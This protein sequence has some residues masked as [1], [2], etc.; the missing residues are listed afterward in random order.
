MTSRK[1]K[2]R[3]SGTVTSQATGEF[4][5]NIVIKAV[6]INN[7]GPIL[8]KA[9]TNKKGYYK[10][11]LDFN[12]LENTEIKEIKVDILL[13]LE[14]SKGRLIRALKK[15]IHILSTKDD[16]LDISLQ[17]IE[18]GLDWQDMSYI[19]GQ[20]VNLKAVAQLSNEELVQT[21]RYLRKRTKKLKRKA[22]VRK[23][24][25]GLFHKFTNPN[26]DCGEGR[27]E[28]IHV[29]MEDRGS[30][31]Q[32][33][34]A[35]DLPAGATVHWFFTN[36]IQVKY[37]TDAA[38]PNDRVNPALPASDQQVTLSDGTPIGWIR[39]NLSD[40]HP[41]NTEVS[42]AYV[43]RVGLIAEFALSRF[44]SLAFAMRDPRN[45]AS[46][47]EYRIRD[48]AG[49]AGQ[50]SGS[51]SHVEVA[52]SNSDLQNLHTVP[53]EMFHQVQYRYNNTTTRS[54]IYGSLREGGSRF[55]EDNIND[56]PNRYVAQSKEIFDDPS[57]S[58][59]DSVSVGTS[60]GSST[61]IR[62]AAALFWK[63]IAEHHSTNV[64]PA[65]EPVIGI[66]SYRKVLE[67][68][69]TVQMSDP[70][71]GYD[72][73]VLRTARSGMPYYGRLDQFRYYDMA[74]TELDH[75]ET[76]WANYL[77]ANYV[78]STGNPVAD[79]RF[80]Y[81]EDQ[82]PVTWPSTVANLA[83][84]QAFI[85]PGDNLT[86]AQ[87]ASIS[88]SVVGHKQ[89]SSRY[90]RV[91][92][93]GSPGPRL[94]RI[95]LI[96][97]A[98]MTDPLIQILRLGASSN[99]IDINRSDKM[100][101][102]KT[103]N[104][105]GLSQVIVI[106]A[107]RINP[108]D[109]T[110]QFDEVATGAD[111][112]ITRWNSAVGTEYEIDPTGWSWT[113]ISP[114]VMV[115]NN[116]DGFADT[117]VFFGQNNKLK[118]RLRNRGNANAS[119]IQIDFWYQKATPFLNSGGWIPVQDVNG[120]TQQITGGTLSSGSYNWFMVNWAPVDDGT[121]HPHWCVKVKVT[122]PGE[123]NIDNKM[124]FSN[125]GNVTTP[126]E[127]DEVRILVRMLES[128]GNSELMVIPHGPLY[129]FEAPK[130]PNGSGIYKCKC[131][132][133]DQQLML[134]TRA[135]RT[136]MKVLERKLKPWDR[137]TRSLKPLQEYY[138]HVKTNTLP[139]GVDPKSLVT[140][141]ELTDGEVMGGITY[142]VLTKTSRKTTKK[143]NR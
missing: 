82:D 40:L 19:A 3:I 11:V 44:I 20:P 61:S 126:G 51:W 62:Y 4:I 31:N 55:I 15:P 124:C 111:T 122:V 112:M 38:Y 85:Q 71:V 32:L 86:L 59:A 139:P 43:Q 102:D 35:D 22:L 95:S 143:S 33:G 5:S 12:S 60:I 141:V 130:L 9:V 50:T 97:S 116:N 104:L 107:A 72:P 125:F 13:K 133:N 106:V 68:A 23:A 108:G 25:P 80:E 132:C 29:I 42:P 16:R 84:L 65:N 76:T 75:H 94:L 21:Y 53:H 101:Y 14:D 98:G 119:G 131:N 100:T 118:V 87:G 128:Y 127:G 81:M 67:A 49:A 135:I 138:Y 115:D 48:Q 28:V 18:Y 136:N 27:L 6:N 91:T 134:P 69:A 88:R 109:Y 105:N 57:Q 2:Y 73:T 90:Y 117:V 89:W 63:Y 77:I 121:H 1:L 142:E 54:G 36:S 52:P 99:L 45:G 41:D 39:A 26:D 78:H 37:T 83:S 30:S 47:L 92:P 96:S 70:G 17:F 110:I 114:D 123:P 93:S 120:T 34:D 66:D 24:F 113:W 58:I 64:T 140:V 79:R 74:F 8:G 7:K 103:I 56:Q 46:R 10:L 137:Q 129:T